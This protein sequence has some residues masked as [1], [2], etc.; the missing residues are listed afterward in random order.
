VALA[1]AALAWGAWRFPP[2]SCPWLYPP[3][4]SHALFGVYCPGCGSTRMLVRLAHGDLAG[5]F[6]KNPLPFI[7]LPFLAYGLGAEL[8][9]RR[10]PSLPRRGWPIY[11]LLAVLLLYWVA[12]NIPG[13]IFDCLRPH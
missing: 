8:S 11:A 3:C 7:L 12:R 5:A 10:W 1:L 2:E 6:A 9:G 13:P 4:P